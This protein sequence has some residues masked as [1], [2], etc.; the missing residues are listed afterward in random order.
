MDHFCSIQRNVMGVGSPFAHV[1]HGGRNMTRIEL[2]RRARHLSENPYAYIDGE[3]HYDALVQA[4]AD[5]IHHLRRQLQNPWAYLD[6]SGAFAGVVGK[7]NDADARMPVIAINKI[8]GRRKRARRYTKPEIAALVRKLQMELWGRR[9]QI[10]GDISGE[11]PED[12]LDPMVALKA[13]GFQVSVAEMLGQY[14]DDG[15]Q[16][17]VAGI[18]DAPNRK[19]YLS[20]NFSPQVRKFTA[21]HELGHAILHGGAGLH[22][23][24]AVDGTTNTGSRSV[25]E[26]EADTFAAF[27]LLPEKPVVA[28]FRDKFLECPFSLNEQTAF[29]LMS[30]D[31]DSVRLKCRTLRDLTRILSSAGYYNGLHFSS[32]AAQFGVS[33]E[34]MA[35][36]LEELKLVQF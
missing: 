15:D 30:Q 35:I 36:R 20:R 23:D 5:N 21:A 33:I 34:A 29:A 6:G 2:I 28:A 32:L 18:I 19:T 9:T 16:F 24:R 12:V 8:N 14:S 22:R 3:G 27:F 26:T 11:Q 4:D 31:V 1:L 13:L 7:S 10:L 17:E 25:T